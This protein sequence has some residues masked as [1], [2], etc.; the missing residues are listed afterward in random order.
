[1][2]PLA[3][4]DLDNTLLDRHAAF[5]RWA[6]EFASARSLPPGAPDLLVELDADGS[7]SRQDVFTRARDHFSLADSVGALIE[8]YHRDYPVHFTFPDGSRSGLRA[9][10]AAGWKVGIVTNG[11]AFQ[12]R[13]LDVARLVD[14]V[15]GVCISDLV[16][17][18]KP[19]PAIF[20]EA[21]RRCGSELRGWMVGD[22]GTADIRG[23]Q[24]VGLRTVW[25]T[26][27][28]TWDLGDPGP[29]ACVDTVTRSVA[30]ILGGPPPG[31]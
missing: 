20:E 23:G 6:E 17:A 14:E 26:R 15:D 29:D 13:K 28:R 12:Q 30:V 27:G 25:M 24:G 3:L 1:V 22:S 9:L 4:F 5:R 11:F 19:D 31:A 18:W 21:A 16:G 10:R 2:A 7:T 8:E